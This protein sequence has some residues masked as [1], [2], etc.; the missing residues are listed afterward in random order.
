[1]A[2]HVVSAVFIYSL[3]DRR[4]LHFRRGDAFGD[5]WEG[6]EP[7]PYVARRRA[8]LSASGLGEFAAEQ[9]YWTEQ[10][11]RYVEVNC[12]FA[13]ESESTAMWSEYGAERGSLAVRTTAVALRR[14][15]LGS[16]REL[17]GPST[18][19]F[20]IYAIQYVDFARDVPEQIG[21]PFVLKRREFQAEREVRV[22][23]ETFTPWYSNPHGHP[24]PEFPEDGTD[25][26]I[27]LSFIDEVRLRPKEQSWVAESIQSLAQRFNVRVSVTRS[28]LEAL[29]SKVAS[30]PKMP[31]P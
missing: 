10:G 16:I 26:A 12:W 19:R 9:E 4:S 7:E 23:R 18:H 29:P 15:L 13:D 2:V 8:N 27:S 24:R 20:W 14:R 21:T 11:R 22:I 6:F 31:A 25:I 28:T 1:L 30:R 3:L 5:E 17:P